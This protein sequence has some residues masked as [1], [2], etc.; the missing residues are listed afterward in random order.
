MI[1]LW[2]ADGCPA[3]KQAVKL[4]EKASFEWR[5]VDVSKTNFE[6]MIPRLVLED[7]THIVNL[8]PINTYIKENKK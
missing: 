4:L 2:G 3:C 6:G 1:E 5:Y 7:G 8:G